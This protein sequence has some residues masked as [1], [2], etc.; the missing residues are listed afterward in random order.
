M[1]VVVIAGTGLLE[2]M[3]LADGPI[4]M[5]WGVVWAFLAALVSG[6]FAIRF[7]VQLLRR[8]RFHVF[9]PYCAVVGS[10]TLLWAVM[11]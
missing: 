5:E 7:L 2:A 8:G 9:A 1:A 11:R 6:V 3:H 4:V 10:L